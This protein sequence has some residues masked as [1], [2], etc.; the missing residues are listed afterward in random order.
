MWWVPC[1]MR[2]VSMSRLFLSSI[3]QMVCEPWV[4]NEMF[5]NFIF[6]SQRF[7]WIT[8]YFTW[9]CVV[10]YVPYL[11]LVRFPAQEYP[12]QRSWASIT[13]FQRNV[14]IP[15]VYFRNGV[16]VVYVD[17]IIY[18]VYP[19]FYALFRLCP[20]L[21]FIISFPVKHMIINYEYAR[22]L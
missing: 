3:S 14:C 12:I 9:F 15:L 18:G 7:V 11:S 21:Y 13:V 4:T 22:K 5:L 10:F 2:L 19:H 6:V 16:P 17:D 20:V 1:T 8:S